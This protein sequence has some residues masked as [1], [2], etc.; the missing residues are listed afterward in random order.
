MLEGYAGRGTPRSYESP[1]TE[2]T[3]YALPAIR[4]LLTRPGDR[5]MPLVSGGCWWVLD[6]DWGA[7]S[8]SPPARAQ[9]SRGAGW[10]GP[11]GIRPR[12]R[13]RVPPTT[14][15]RVWQR[16]EPGGLAQDPSCF[17]DPRRI[18]MIPPEAITLARGDPIERRRGR[19]SPVRVRKLAR[20]CRRSEDVS[21]T[22]VT[23]LA[24]DARSSARAGVAGSQRRAAGP[25]GPVPHDHG[26]RVAASRAE[27][28]AM[29]S[30]CR[31]RTSG[32]TEWC[33]D[34]PHCGAKAVRRTN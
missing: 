6:F 18:R 14:G 33:S 16:A 26:R 24:D 28:E 17:S 13:A 8:Y 31:R 11:W 5:R 30:A 32:T 9:D 34:A 25:A 7:E 10:S 21:M 20:A 23:R 29:R 27:C 2:Q 3:G 12:R 4:P 22:P 19:A 15:R 1:R